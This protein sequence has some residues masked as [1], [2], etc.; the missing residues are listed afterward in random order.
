MGLRASCMQRQSLDRS[1]SLRLRH[2]SLCRTP[3]REEKPAHCQNS[4]W[5][6]LLGLALL[7]AVLPRKA[8][9]PA[10]GRQTTYQ[11]QCPAAPSDFQS[12]SPETERSSNNW[13]S[14]AKSPTSLPISDRRP[15]SKAS[16]KT[17]R[18]F[19]PLEFVGQAVEC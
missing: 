17:S 1:G 12:R 3:F 9:R 14:A 8:V 18:E 11:K 10:V 2:Q 16:G 4:P 5:H 19:A 13:S 7:A 6:Q 15:P